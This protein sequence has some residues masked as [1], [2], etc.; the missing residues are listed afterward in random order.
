MGT[1][2]SWNLEPPWHIDKQTRKGWSKNWKRRKQTE[3]SLLGD[4]AGAQ[5]SLKT[6]LSWPNL[7][8]T[9][10]QRWMGW[11]TE[12]QQWHSL[13]SLYSS[14]SDMRRQKPIGFDP[15]HFPWQKVDLQYHMTLG[16]NFYPF[17]QHSRD[18]VTAPA[19]P[20]EWGSKNRTTR[21]L[22]TKLSLEPQPTK[23]GQNLGVQLKKGDCL[24]K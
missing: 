9:P 12:G 16:S 6:L 2:E 3:P 24:L 14:F 11:S 20:E 5:F 10:G 17:K 22:K 4:T 19:M 8:S 18:W 21:V 7:Y 15:S 1:R 23:V 13:A